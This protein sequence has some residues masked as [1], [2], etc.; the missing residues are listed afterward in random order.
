MIRKVGH[1]VAFHIDAMWESQELQAVSRE[2]VWW[3]PRDT[4]SDYLILANEGQNTI[5]L[6]LSL[7]DAGGKQAQQSLILGPRE[8]ARYSVRKLLQAAGLSGSYGGIQVSGT[9]HSGSLNTLHF[10]F[11]ETA[12]FSAL[13]KMFNH[14]PNTKLEERDFAKTAI[15]TL[16]APMLALSSPD[17]ALAF[18]PG[19]TLRPQIFVRNTTAKPVDA[20]VRFN[21]RAAATAGKT[22]GP[23]LH[24]KPY[25]TR[26]IDVA[27]LQRGTTLPK[28]ANWTSVTLTT[29]SRPEEV[30]AVATSYDETPRYGAQ[31]P[32]SDQLSFR[33]EGGMWEYDPYHSSIITA[34]NGGTKPTQ[35]AFTIFY[36]QGTHAEIL[37]Q[38]LAVLVGTCSRIALPTSIHICPPDTGDRDE[39]FLIACGGGPPGLYRG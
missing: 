38:N 19:T 24:L 33:W 9:A 2:G 10:L 23:Q 34:G 14:D 25:E 1:P 28:E 5:P 18:P 29:N 20:A 7:Y 16:R 31:T 6:R 32:F 36:N 26:Q 8:T 3:L 39:T 37:R 27:A 30:M 22:L 4:T 13:L 21:W 12:G 11:D 35:A 17:P 15:W